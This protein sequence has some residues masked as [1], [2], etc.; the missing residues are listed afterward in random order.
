MARR[1]FITDGLCFIGLSCV[2]LVGGCDSGVRGADGS[3]G[4]PTNSLL[5]GRLVFE[6]G[7]GVHT[8]IEQEPNDWSD[9]SQFLGQP[10]DGQEYR[11]VGAI[12][13]PPPDN[14]VDT[15][16]F[17]TTTPLTVTWRA[18]SADPRATSQFEADI[19]VIDFLTFT[20]DLDGLRSDVFADCVTGVLSGGAGS[21]DAD[22][23]FEIVVVPSRGEGSYVLE[24]AFGP[25]GN[26]PAASDKHHLPAG[27]GEG[28]VPVRR[29]YEPPRGDVV[30]G[31]VLATFDPA[32][33]SEEV[34]T[35]ARTRGLRVIERAPCGVYR[36]GEMI[37]EA[38]NKLRTRMRTHKTA[39]DLAALPGVRMAEPN[40]RLTSSVRQ[41]THSV[42]GLGHSPSLSGNYPIAPPRVSN[43][44]RSLVEGL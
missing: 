7:P 2:I 1:R 41:K 29:T 31:E 13:S 27:K 30:I 24:V 26:V 3:E 40:R 17:T 8:V 6:T 5:E 44:F 23:T 28:P 20:C 39:T 9:G 37:P 36:L 19:G 11:I 4:Q 38:G 34:E 35:L 14:D 43:R 25:P 21:F 22:G 12:S 10:S 42:S 18:R 33:S 15:Y 32:V 16:R